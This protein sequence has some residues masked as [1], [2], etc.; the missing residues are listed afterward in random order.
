ALRL[1]GV[2]AVRGDD[3]VFVTADFAG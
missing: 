3:G 1:A 2:A